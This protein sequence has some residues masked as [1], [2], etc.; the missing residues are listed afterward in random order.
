MTGGTLA[1]AAAEGHRVVV[2]VATNGDRGLTGAPFQPDLGRRRL[3][4]LETSSAVLG[5]SRVETLGYGDSGMESALPPPRGSFCAAAAE[6]AAHRLASILEREQADV[7]TIYDANGGYGHR[8]HVHVHD[9]GLLAASEAGT[10]LVLEATVER[11]SLVR[12]VRLLGR[13]GIRPGGVTAAGLAASYRPR[14]DI[15]HIVDVRR[16]AS[17]KRAAMAAH[18]SQ[19]AGGDDVRTL[20]LLRALPA[21]LFRRVLGREW[22]VEIG[23]PAR[24]QPL[25]DVFATLRS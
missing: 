3:R 7:L 8:D 24:A 13:L 11:E 1:R 10:P 23:R 21:P 22:F 14:R 12:A 2:V 16:Y 17:L 19:T 20:R 25:D 18:A 4:E 5:V 15:T 6:E 9:V